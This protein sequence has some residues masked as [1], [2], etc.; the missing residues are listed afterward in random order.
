MKVKCFH[1][2]K[3]FKKY[4]N[5]KSKRHFCSRECWF[6]YCAENLGDWT[7]PKKIIER[8]KEKSF[9]EK[10]SIGLKEYYERHYFDKLKRK[11]NFDYGWTGWKILREKILNRD[12][13]CQKCG[14]GKN[15]RI[16]HIIPVKAGG[17]HNPENLITL[18]N[19]CHQFI[20]KNQL[21]IYNI[22]NDW[23][24]TRILILDSLFLKRIITDR[25]EKFT[26]EKA[27]E[28]E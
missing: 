1:C 13:V 12:K 18:C 20:E 11:D 19:K 25:W 9:R 21:G 10:V 5:L 17:K 4:S 14:S 24:I 27:V 2:G 7:N 28:I 16:H 26:G 8:N 6:H 22:V 23:E 15:L 3:E